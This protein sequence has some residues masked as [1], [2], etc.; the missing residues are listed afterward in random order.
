MNVRP[1][2]VT[3]LIVT[4]VWS[5]SLDIVS[6]DDS[7][8]IGVLDS[9]ANE[10][11]KC[12]TTP[13][14]VNDDGHVVFVTQNGF[15]VTDDN[16]AFDVYQRTTDKTTSVSVYHPIFN[17]LIGS[18]H[19]EI[20][21][22]ANVQTAGVVLRQTELDG[23]HLSLAAR[24]VYLLD[25][26]LNEQRF[27]PELTNVNLPAISYDGNAI[28]FTSAETLT[29]IDANTVCAAVRG[30]GWVLRE[31]SVL[32]DDSA[33][34]GDTMRLYDTS[35]LLDRPFLRYGTPAISH[36]D[37]YGL[38]VAFVSNAP[39]LPGAKSG[40]PY[41]YLN[42]DGEPTV[43]IS[44]RHVAG[45]PS[46]PGPCYAP[47][48][49]GDG[50]FVAFV[51]D[52]P[53][54]AVDLLGDGSHIYI[55]NRDGTL[56]DAADATRSIVD[57][58]AA[59]VPANADSEAPQ[60]NNDGRFVAFRSQATNLA[61]ETDTGG[62]W[63]VYVRDSEAGTTKCISAVDG[64]GADADCFAPGISPTG[65]YVTFITNATNLGSPNFAYQV[66][67]YDSGIA[68][69]NFVP[70][71]QASDVNSDLSAP[72]TI[73]LSATDGDNDLLAY[74]ITDISGL[75][76]GELYDGLVDD[77]NVITVGTDAAPFELQGNTLTYVPFQN[78]A[79][80]GFFSFKVREIGEGF[81]QFSDAA[82]VDIRVL[83]ISQGIISVLSDRYVDND[84]SASE[85][86]S[87]ASLAGRIEMDAGGSNVVFSTNDIL[88]PADTN[89][90]RDVFLFDRSS[91][92]QMT[93]L[94]SPGIASSPSSDSAS[95]SPDGSYVTFQ[96]SASLAPDDTNTTSDVYL[97]EVGSMIYTPVS[98]D[99]T[100]ASRGHSDWPSVAAYGDRVAFVA[101]DPNSGIDQIY[102]WSNE[103]GSVSLL[104]RDINGDPASSDCSEPMISGD[105]SVVVF[106]SSATLTAHA[107][108]DATTV[109]ARVIAT[110]ETVAVSRGDV[111]PD[112]NA[113]RP[114]VS[115]YGMLVAFASR[116]TN[117]VD[118]PDINGDTGDLYLY[119]LRNDT[120]TRAVAPANG[121]DVKYPRISY[122]GRFVYFATPGAWLGTEWDTAPHSF[123]QAYVFDRRTDTI[124]HVSIRSDQPGDGSVYRGAVVV[125]ASGD[126]GV[127]FAS[128][129]SNLATIDTD[130]RADVFF[131]ELLTT[132]NEL[133]ES[134]AP[135]LVS[136]EED[137]EM[138]IQLSATDPDKS[139]TRFSVLSLPA[140]GALLDAGIEIT[141]DGLPWPIADRYQ[142]LT[143]VP[144]L[145]YSNTA[146]DRD[147]FGV[148]V[149][150]M[151][152]PGDTIAIELA[153]NNVNDPPVLD[154][155][156]Q[157]IDEGDPPL[158]V[159]I[160]VSDPDLANAA[161]PDVLA[162]T[163][164][165]A[166]DVVNGTWVYSPTHDIAT[167][168]TTPVV[169]EVTITVDD[170]N[171]GV[172]DV[173]FSL[174]IHD[175]N[176]GP[177]ASS[178]AVSP[179]TPVTTDDL[180]SDYEFNDF[181]EDSEGESLV[182]WFYR[183]GTSGDFTEYTSALT[184]EPAT[185]VPA[186]A[187]AKDQQWY[188]TVQPRDE[189]PDAALGDSV[190]AAPA[191][192]ANSASAV[193]NVDATVAEDESVE[194]DLAASDADGD[195]FTVSLTDPQ[196]GAVS[197]T[198]REG[199]PSVT[200]TP[201]PDY[202]GAD[203]FTYTANDGASDSA[204]AM[205]TIEV[206][207]VP[208]APVLLV[209]ERLVI[210]GDAAEGTI[211]MARVTVAD[212]DYLD[213]LDPNG[214][215]VHLQADVQHAT[216]K[217]RNDIAVT[218]AVP[219]LYASFPLRYT[220][221]DNQFHT[222]TLTLQ[223][224][225]QTGLTSEPVP[226]PII[227]GA[228]IQDLPLAGGWNLISF[229]VDPVDA[230]TTLFTVDGTLL[231][232]GSA[233]YWDGEAI[234]AADDLTGGR[235]YWVYGIEDVLI[236]N[237]PG[238]PLSNVLVLDVDWHGIGPTG[239][240]GVYALP[241]GRVGTVWQ[242]NPARGR[243]SAAAALASGTGYFFKNDGSNVIFE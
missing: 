188:F 112:G 160:S 91:D 100:G 126:L 187:T 104:S 200:Y 144:A 197:M 102:L 33:A 55:L 29:G 44:N 216:L 201:D 75:F 224:S 205:V 195:M 15:D 94:I 137:A 68:F 175:V 227:S 170:G 117:I 79:H 221:T 150:D 194:I 3:I 167:L 66:Y 159:P 39:D 220:R 11:F 140:H 173:T 123:R 84:Y 26:G 178:T 96:T 165:G 174:T 16:P 161:N 89:S 10:T 232:R 17:P 43:R 32:A 130:A 235:A 125:G 81:T 25:G 241:A 31:I 177:V 19:A 106:L 87:P 154:A 129:A 95:L 243:F 86:P 133:P 6:R 114:S 35:I 97:T 37:T 1:I 82:T 24:G 124:R 21:V 127:A 90:S 48:V 118:G 61:P 185:S 218:A 14:S 5:Q 120:L 155:V 230:I 131:S 213:G 191:T 128:T 20:A 158:S 210:E 204:A 226:L 190:D 40:N 51:T 209:T 49:S 98:L 70:V 199:A 145:N 242:W 34:T 135:A 23:S 28:A 56:L 202:Y 101:P 41:V 27:G 181:D 108:D 122:D 88:E 58:N 62:N 109:Y 115:Y 8:L 163:V 65:R 119:D 214:I 116:A 54:I 107:V 168:Q 148:Q 206:T 149:N 239:A 223:V 151:F 208:D 30:D 234:V 60:L 147:S 103:T 64:V 38:Q 171:G 222:E 50:R 164:N 169:M 184:G 99:E 121:H 183:N 134:T 153:V 47:S 85:I 156:D 138:L 113:T 143:Y 141:P 76:D 179:A 42:G 13:A 63:Q 53:Y 236:P 36:T 139:E 4:N 231:I 93:F 67:R 225:D 73:V 80:V 7:D 72:K 18:G 152:G 57:V 74:F 105:G 196:F 211:D 111:M 59:G 198:G 71:A 203:A 219:V 166:G 238:T 207:P 46:D 132:P 186:A 45:Q 182:T 69:D 180:A 12:Q 110:G 22:S 9:G 2:A 215:T 157:V 212:A 192:I 217:D 162:F 77:G 240:A 78:N 142:R 228:Q 233:W 229:A 172:D 83:D 146:A 189:R 237:I 52:D 176:V 193:G 136:G 92:G